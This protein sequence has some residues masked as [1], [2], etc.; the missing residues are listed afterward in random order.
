MDKEHAKG[1]AEKAKG[2]IKDQAGK[3]TDNKK[4]QADA[5]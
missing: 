3:L 2:T 1:L 5:R 4:M